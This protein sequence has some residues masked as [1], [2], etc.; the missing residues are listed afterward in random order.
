MKRVT[1]PIASCAFISL[2]SFVQISSINSHSSESEEQSANEPHCIAWCFV[3]K[4]SNELLDHCKECRP[5]GEKH[6]CKKDD[7]ACW[8]RCKD[9]GS[10]KSTEKLSAPRNLLVEYVSDFALS[11]KWD[12]VDG[13]QLYVVQFKDVKEER[14]WQD[15]P[16]L[17]TQETQIARFVPPSRML[18]DEFEFRVAAV[19]HASGVGEFSNSTLLGKPRPLMSAKMR[20]HSMELNNTPFII[21]SQSEEGDAYRPNGTLTIALAYDVHS[22]IFCNYRWY[23]VERQSLEWPFGNDDLEVQPTFHM[24]TCADPDLGVA[25]PA[26]DFY[27]GKEPNTVEAKMGADMMYR[28]CRFVYA[29]EEVRSRH[30]GSTYHI[31]AGYNEFSS[32]DITCDKVTNCKKAES[33]TKPPIC[34][35]IQDFDFNVINEDQVDW[36]DRDSRLAVNVSFTPII[37]RSQTKKPLYYVAFYGNAVNY[38]NEE[39]RTFLGVN[40][41]GILGNVSN[42]ASFMPDGSCQEISPSENSIVIG[43]LTKGQLYGVM[44]CGVMDPKNLSFPSFDVKQKGLKIR[45]NALMIQ[46]PEPQKGLLWTIVASIALFLMCLLLLSLFLWNRHQRDDIRSKKLKLQVMKREAEQRYTEMPKKDDL[47]ELERRNLIIY[48]EKKLGS[49]AFG[50]VY[51]GRLIGAAKGSRDAQST[52][53]VNLMRAENCEVAVKMLPE[54]A[55]EL[56][57]SEFLREICLMKCLGYHERLVNMLACVTNSEPYCLVVEYCSDG[58]LLHFLRERCAYM[59]KLDEEK[60]DYSDPNCEY[61][62]DPDMVMTVKQLLM[63]AVQISYGLEYLSQKGFVHRDVAA[64]NI[65]VHDKHYAKIGDF[66]L[67]RYIYADSSNYKSKGGRLPVKWMSIEAIRHYEFTT[68]SD[69]WSFGVLMFEIITLGGTPYPGIQPAD[70]LSFLENHGRIPQPDNCPDEFYAV[71]ESCW[72]EKPEQRPA[73]PSIRQKLAAQLESITDDSCYSYL[74]LDAGK[75]YYNASKR[76]RIEQAGDV[77]DGN[78]TTVS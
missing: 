3:A 70:M 7:D 11:I 10:G 44:I 72:K 14:W 22:K 75:D 35:Q 55:D 63:F 73:F 8:S 27:K 1:F 36:N 31:S 76:D 20:V 21:D 32:V 77:I 24:M 48:D 29:V 41:T 59:L 71:M 15:V 68:S 25:V 66:G 16:K 12:A 57:K 51:L 67:C 9:L 33:S 28:R 53:G 39:E 58:D 17:A 30:C 69:V 50:A 34:G 47:W 45:N 4:C 42:C 6:L 26:P 52:L 19:S 62:F 65:L 61:S 23:K 43:N 60:I 78:S 18:C 2:L 64:R 13:A 38:T 37:R 74:K 40:M 54:Y 46:P 5:Y 49:G 56:S